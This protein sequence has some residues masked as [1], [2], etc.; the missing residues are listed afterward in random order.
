MFNILTEQEA[1]SH[2]TVGGND[3]IMGDCLKV[4]PL[5]ASHSVDLV[6]ADLP[7]G[8]TSIEWDKC[9]PLNKLW[10]H[11]K[12]ILKP[13]GCAV[14]F[15][16]QPFT[17]RLI[18]SNLE[19][20]KYNLVWNKNKS[21]SP[22]LAKHQPMR[23]HEDIIVFAKGKT[24]YNPIMEKGTPYAR[25]S[26]NPEGYVGKKNTH[27]YGLKPTKG[28]T[29]T[30][31]RYPKSILNI[32]RDFSAQQGCHPTQKPIPVCEWL[33]RTYSNPGELVLDNV[34]GSGSTLLAAR[35]T[36]RYGIGIENDP[37]Y[38]ETAKQRLGL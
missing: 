26:S 35:N 31:T 22:G 3:L 20:F 2:G 8:I 18:L 32:S 38:F 34:M 28:F 30:G 9:I 19:W 11:Y 14:F 4:M 7:Y 37:V 36:G 29:N 16:L 33:I 5:I 25:S 1:V 21:G 15:G 27:G 24:T 6:L 23:V 10:Y 17:S 13:T 12:R